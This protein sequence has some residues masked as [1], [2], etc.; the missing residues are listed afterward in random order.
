MPFRGPAVAFAAAALRVTLL[1]IA[2]A[3]CSSLDSVNPVNWWHDLEGGPIAQDRPPPPNADAPYGNLDEVPTT[4]PKND[5]ASRDRIADAL[6]ADRANAQY[7]ASLAPLPPAPAA[8]AKPVTP[9]Q[10]PAAPADASN[11]SLAAANAPPPPPQANAP[12]ASASQ[13][14][15]SQ[16]N[17]PQANAPLA[18]APKATAAPTTPVHDSLLPPPSAGPIPPTTE[19]PPVPE[20]PP[21][22]AVLAGAPAST[23]PSPPPAAPKPPPPAPAPLVVGAPV[24]VAFPPG[25]A[26]L[27]SAALPGLKLLARGR[28]AGVIGITGF[29]EARDATPE[30]QQ[31]AMPLAMARV[32]AIAAYLLELGVPSAALRIDGEAQGVGAVARVIK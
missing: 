15:A 14:N 26:A 30:A 21:A 18:S 24:T 11:A 20:T 9:P 5:T 17:A 7:D 22:P 19:L 28:G 6:V 1:V 2:V 10:P 4:V 3:G 12:Q 8:A 25:S 32:R 13:G 27:P 29:G 23:A 31:A 16:G